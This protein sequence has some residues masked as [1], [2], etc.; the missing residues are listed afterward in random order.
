MIRLRCHYIT[1]QKKTTCEFLSIGFGVKV[2]PVHEAINFTLTLGTALT[3]FLG[4]QYIGHA[5]VRYFNS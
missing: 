2:M 5:L 4:M 3:L 1:G